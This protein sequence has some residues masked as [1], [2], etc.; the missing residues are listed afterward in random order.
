MPIMRGLYVKAGF[1]K[2]IHRPL[3]PEIESQILHRMRGKMSVMFQVAVKSKGEIEVIAYHL[4]ILTSLAVE[5]HWVLEKWRIRIT[6]SVSAWTSQRRARESLASDPQRQLPR[7]IEANVLG[8][9]AWLPKGSC[10]GVSLEH[11]VG[12]RITILYT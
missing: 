7:C 8:A 5:G 11:A 4:E 6:N 10:R 2:S 1:N 9:A 12:A 3:T